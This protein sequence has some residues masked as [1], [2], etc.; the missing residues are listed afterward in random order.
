MRYKCTV[1]YIGA[2]Y[3]GWQTQKKGTSIQEKIEE[4]LFKITNE[5]III[6]G[7]GRTDAKVN[8]DGQV[9]HFDSNLEMS[10]Y[11]WKGAINAFLPNDIY[12]KNV[13]KETETF[14]ARHCVKQK[15]Y[16]YHIITTY[17]VFKKDYASFIP[18]ELNVEK[19]KEASKCFIGK[20]D[21]TS[22]NSSSLEEYSDQVRTIS[23]INITHNEEEIILNFIGKGFLRYMVRMMVAALI[24]VGKGKMTKE[25]IISLLENPSKT[26]FSKN[27][28]AQGLTLKRV[29]YFKI[30]S[31]NEEGMI[32]ERLRD[33][34]ISDNI[35]YVFTTRNTQEILGYLKDDSSIVVYDDKNNEL[36]EELMKDI[37]NNQ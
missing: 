22:F 16:E 29:D 27:A 1:S 23:E 9:F 30:L 26:A 36:A 18:Y 35:D 37:I 34:D 5:E 8:A 4:A 28:E 11:K 15:E 17:D 7:S 2:N 21:F 12:I 20:H 24:E 10:E 3:E 33:D 14:H 13:E 31:L 6:V 25:D 32:R 19:M